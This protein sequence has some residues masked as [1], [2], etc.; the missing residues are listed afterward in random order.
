MRKD[1]QRELVRQSLFTKRELEWK[2][3][4]LW[5]SYA[6]VQAILDQKR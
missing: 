4:A 6:E 3:L 5:I 2:S 1:H